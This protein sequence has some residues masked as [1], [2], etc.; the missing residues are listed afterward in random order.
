[1]LQ[2]VV[3]GPPRNLNGV[4]GALRLLLADPARRLVVTRWLGVQS[5]DS[6]PLRGELETSA[7]AVPGQHGVPVGADPRLNLPQAGGPTTCDDEYL[8]R[9]TARADRGCPPRWLQFGVRILP[10]IPGNRSDSS[11]ALSAS[12]FSDRS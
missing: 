4:Q 11:C 2:V 12:Q 5:D 8:R 1:M 10:Q 7:S 6:L 9:A 3:P